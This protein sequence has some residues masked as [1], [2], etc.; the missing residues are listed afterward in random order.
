MPDL[1]DAVDDAYNVQ[2][3]IDFGNGLQLSDGV[4][5][6]RLG[7][8]FD[9]ARKV[10]EG[11]YLSRDDI[12]WKAAADEMLSLIRGV[13]QQAGVNPNYYV[14]TRLAG[15]WAGRIVGAALPSRGEVE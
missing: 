15:H 7:L 9:A 12:D 3:L 2:D 1:S 8:V 6:I 11:E 13:L 14:D 5:R 10:A 4:D